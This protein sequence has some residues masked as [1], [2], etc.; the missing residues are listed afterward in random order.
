MVLPTRFQKLLEGGSRR[1][2]VHIEE[3]YQD[4]RVLIPKGFYKAKG[5]GTTNLRA[6]KI[7]YGFIPTPYTLEEGDGLWE[8]SIRRPS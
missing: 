6:V 8:S 4:L 1:L 2:D 3:S 7:S 5:I